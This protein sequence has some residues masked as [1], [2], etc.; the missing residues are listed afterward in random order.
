MRRARVFEF[1]RRRSPTK[2]TPAET[3]VDPRGE[4]TKRQNSWSPVC[5]VV[6]PSLN[7]CPIAR[8][9]L[10]S[11]RLGTR[12]P[13]SQIHQNASSEFPPPSWLS[14]SACNSS[15]VPEQQRKHGTFPPRPIA[16]T[17]VSFTHLVCSPHRRLLQNRATIEDP[18][19]YFIEIFLMLLL[20]CPC[21]MRKVP[22]S[23]RLSTDPEMLYFR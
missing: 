12:A 13:L 5:R 21:R 7:P 15:A 14:A 8:Q 16:R 18:H 19:F 1:S 9:R 10:P 22:I 11:R 20:A 3:W 23:R 6:F 17:C 2:K 4:E